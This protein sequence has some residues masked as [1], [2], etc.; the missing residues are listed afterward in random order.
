MLAIT[1]PD[2]ATQYRE[3]LR[4]YLR[5]G[6]ESHLNKAYDLG[7]EAI[8]S[9]YGLVEMIDLHCTAVAACLEEGVSPLS[10][11]ET[12]AAAGYMLMQ[13]TAPFNIMQISHSE[14][15]LA[16]RRL[17]ALFDESTN[18]FAHALHDDACQMLSL[19]YLELSQLREEVPEPTRERV[20]LLGSYLDHIREQLR[21]LSHELRPPM[22]EHLGLLPC[23]RN[24]AIGFART[25]GLDISVDIPDAKRDVFRS[26][27]LPLYRA[28]HEALTNIARHAHAERAWIALERFPDR[29]ECSVRDDGV[30]FD[31]DTHAGADSGEGLGI[32]NLRERIGSLQGT[33]NIE[34]RP[35][36]GTCVCLSLPLTV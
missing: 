9:G 36:K 12:S 25:Y 35:G 23:I 13:A 27:E 26:V 24:L 1:T 18:R 21:H 31:P 2:L 33:V 32:I 16:L 19:A 34:S 11:A 4:D 20:D 14:N 15:N 10:P 29:V 30:G 8:G 17:N 5:D 7:H 3:A 22:L 6:G 28:I